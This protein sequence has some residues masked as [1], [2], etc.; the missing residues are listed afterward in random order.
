MTIFLHNVKRLLLNKVQFFFIILFPLA[1]M[2]IGFIEGE[3]NLKVVVAI[4]DQDQTEF[5]GSLIGNLKS[6]AE[7]L[8]IE[9]SQIEKELKSLRIDYVLV[10]ERGF[11]EHVIGGEN[12]GITGYSVQESNYSMPI[13]AF[14]E[15]WI[16]HAKIIADAVNHEEASFYTEFAHYDQLRPVQVDHRIVTDQ[17][18]T[19][20]TTMSV[21]GFVILS[22]LFTSLVICLFILINK[23]NHTLYRTLAAPV[24]IRNYMVQTISSFLFVSWIQITVVMMMLKWVYGM[25]MGGAAF[26]IYV[27]LLLFSLVSV[28]FGVVMSSLSRSMTQAWTFGIC[29]IMPMCMLGGAF[30]PL[31]AMPDLIKNIS[32]LVPVSWVMGGIEE[33]LQGQG[34]SS[35]GKEI[36][37]L[38]L[39][40][41]IFFMVGT[42]RKADIAQ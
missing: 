25:S 40:A 16:G 11:T 26:D 1:F 9:E 20:K 19:E 13:S 27:L 36:S 15:Q 29:I 30:F 8:S 6:K 7:I 34:L 28:S 12:G 41:V 33:L 31:D 37:I 35:I 38:L 32:R 3:S 22:M 10:L 2:Q 39:F 17:G 14:L 24:T 23:N 21:I 5:T 42:L 4:I 18:E